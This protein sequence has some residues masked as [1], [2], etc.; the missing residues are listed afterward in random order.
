M[1][2]STRLTSLV[3]AIA[4]LSVSAATPIIFFDR[5]ADFFEET[6]VIGNGT[7]GGIIY[8]N[9]SKER[10]SLNDITFWSGEPDSAVYTPGA[11]KVIPEIRAAIDAG[12]Y[13]LAQKLQKKVQGHYTNNYQPIGNLFIDFAD[14]SEA[15]NYSRK[16]NIADAT[17]KVV[18]SK[19][20]NEITTE[21]I[22]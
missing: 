9:P 18:Y 8:G 21:Y 2:L 13:Q 1:K 6:F 17:A 16:L 20:D 15:S 10:I 3:V 22:A 19:G 5:P 12:D 11:Y 7:Q 14:K 4:S